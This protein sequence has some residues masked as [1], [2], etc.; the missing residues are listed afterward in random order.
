MKGTTVKENRE[1]SPEVLFRQYYPRLCDFAKRLLRDGEQAKDVAQDAFVSLL[2]HQGAMSDHPAAIK[3][4]LYSSVKYGC[5]NRLRHQQVE[6]RYEQSHP[7]PLTDGKH[8][9]SA[10]IDAEI[11]GEVREALHALPTGCALVLRKGYLEG[12][13]NPQI[14]KELGISVNTVKSQKQRALTLLRERLSPQAMM[15]LLPFLLS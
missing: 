7:L 15:L 14:A 13:K 5:L 1:F 10:M 9:L 4:F 8:I 11:L 3:A 6:K 2:E 12:L